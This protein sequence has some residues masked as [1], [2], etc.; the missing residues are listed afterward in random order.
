[1]TVL[2]SLVRDLREMPSHKLF[3]VAR[4]IH[5]LHPKSRERSD[6][7]LVATAG[8]MSGEEGEE[9]ECAVRAEADRHDGE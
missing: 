4:F 5:R 1:M 8:C 3:E 9:F 6:A 7:A 2:E